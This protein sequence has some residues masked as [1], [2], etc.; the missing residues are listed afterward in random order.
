MRLLESLF[1]I[2]FLPVLFFKQRQLKI[3]VCFRNYADQQICQS[4]IESHRKMNILIGLLMLGTIIAIL[5]SSSRFLQLL[6]SP[7]QNP[8]SSYLCYVTYGISDVLAV[9]GLIAL[10]MNFL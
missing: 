6:F 7:G 1:K 4:G 5:Q 3:F 10:R 2:F 9:A 8:S